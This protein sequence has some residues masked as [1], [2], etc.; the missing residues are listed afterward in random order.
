MAIIEVMGA[1]KFRVV[2][3][4]ERDEDIFRDILINDEL[5]FENLFHA[6]MS[7]FD[8]EGDQLAS[9]EPDPRIVQNLGQEKTDELVKYRPNLYSGVVD[10]L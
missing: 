1:I 2:V 10:F 9:F 4:T 8:F 3:D 6:I 7:S 5:T